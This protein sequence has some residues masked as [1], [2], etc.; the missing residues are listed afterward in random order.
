MGGGGGVG[1]F[2]GT[3]D[4]WVVGHLGGLEISENA[5]VEHPS[6]GQLSCDTHPE[7]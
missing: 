7:Q 4:I 6:I 1:V 3:G 5:D 2:A